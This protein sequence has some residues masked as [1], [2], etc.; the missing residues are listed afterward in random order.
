ML[1]FRRFAFALVCVLLPLVIDGTAQAEDSP[2]P[3]K[4]RLGM[5]LVGLQDINVGNN[6]F[7]ADLWVWANH[8]NPRLAPMK[9]LEIVNA[10]ASTTSLQSTQEGDG[11]IW[12][13]EK[14]QGTFRHQWDM[15]NFPFDR[16]VLSVV[17]EE[18]QDDVRKL[19]YVPD[20]DG[21]GYSKDI[22]VNGFNIRN[23]KIEAGERGYDTN[24][25]DPTAPPSTKFGQI[26]LDIEMERSSLVLFLK[27]HAALYA[28]FLVSATCFA[29]LPSMPSTL[30]TI[31]NVVVG[32][33]FAAII[34]LRASDAV[35]GRG[36]SVTLADRLHFV[37]FA[38]FVAL[39]ALTMWVFIRPSE[40]S[41]EGLR[42]FSRWSGWGYVSSYV[43]WNIV[44][45]W[46]AA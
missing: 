14:V 25:G 40:W 22:A 37:T 42:R 38:H 19:T 43:T 10:Q 16:H 6:T 36:E 8:K 9:T 33:L 30:G 28:A 20:L 7:G 46:A 26:R 17:L 2:P 12:S 21:S 45:I 35:M 27:M 29:M 44:L 13:Q 39:G 3:D 31:A 23:V 15:S 5:F 4:V 32:V 18:A 34:N 1:F 41:E 11:N 24:F